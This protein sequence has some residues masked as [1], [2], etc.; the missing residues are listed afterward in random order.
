MK[1]QERVAPCGQ[2]RSRT[3]EKL[4]LTSEEKIA[5]FA[6]DAL[7]AARFK[8]LLARLSIG[9]FLKG[10]IIVEMDSRME[11]LEAKLSRF[12]SQSVCVRVRYGVS[13]AQT[14]HQKEYFELYACA[15]ISDRGK[16]DSV[17]GAKSRYHYHKSQQ[18]L[19][20]S[21]SSVS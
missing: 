21:A 15:E 9:I 17:Q 20:M 13:L 1:G 12:S 3:T 7:D 11:V 16:A 10:V 18:I 5:N 19:G 8:P 14:D 2:S 6:L 4:I